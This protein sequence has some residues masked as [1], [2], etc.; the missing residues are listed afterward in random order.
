MRSNSSPPELTEKQGQRRLSQGLQGCRR[1]YDMRLASMSNIPVVGGTVVSQT[2]L[3]AWSPCSS[4]R[5]CEGSQ[6]PARLQ[7]RQAN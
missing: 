2:R 4:R 5:R 3:L 1:S 7:T 6:R